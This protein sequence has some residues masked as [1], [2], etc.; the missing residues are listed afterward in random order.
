[1]SLFRRVLGLEADPATAAA[2]AASMASAAPTKAVVVGDTESVRRI[3]ARL[4]ALPPERARFIAA[5]AYLLARA[6]EVDLAPSDAEAVEMTRQ[7]TEVGQ[8]DHETA[9]LV[10]ALAETRVEGF[11]ATEDYLVTREFKG[12]STYEDRE[13]LLR[14]C[15]LVAAADDSINAD[16][17][18]LVNRLAEELDVERVDLNRIR[19]EFHDRLA[20]IQELR[21]M[22]T[23]TVQA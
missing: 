20:G 10:V 3:A 18:W 4:D 7:I 14:C 22:R 6:A 11:G 9:S 15:L 1:M 23:E 13:R 2:P 12:I 8:L 17:A 19:E 21:R 16:E 5:F